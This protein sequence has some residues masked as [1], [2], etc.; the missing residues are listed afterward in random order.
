MIILKKELETYFDRLWP[1]TRSI[2]GNGLRKSFKILQEI[3]PLEL[4]EVATGKRVFDWEIPEEWNIRDA[5][6]ET[7][8]G[9]KIAQLADHNLHVVNYSEP[10]DKRI[11]FSELKAH[12]H[13]LPEQPNAIPYLTSYY[14]KTWGF[15]LTHN[16][17]KTLPEK[18]EYRVFIDSSLKPGS[19]TYGQCLLPGK[20]KKEVLFSSY[21]CHPSMANNELSG[22]LALAFLYKQ[23]AAIPE[24][25]Y[26]YRFVLAPETIGVIAFL[27]RF[28][29]QLQENITAGYVLTCCGDPGSFTYKRSKQYEDLCNR[30]AEHVLRYRYPE[31]SVIDFAVGGSDERQYCS[32][33]FNFPVGSLMRTP[34]QR[35]PEYHTSL[36]NKSFLSFEA[37]EETVQAYAQIVQVLEMNGPWKC[38]VPYCEPQLGKRGLYPSSISPDAQREH[39]HDLLHFI[40][41]ADGEH[42]L[43]SVADKRN[44]SALEFEQHL[45][46]CRDKGLI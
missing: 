2:T 15:C 6:I 23:L 4:T 19:L 7:P 16:E 42:D 35:Y 8:D 39:L 26:S 9:R 17:F 13:T 40:S 44:K 27:D 31:H 45:D 14:K 22:P 36:D 18:G 5:Y 11:S 12:L 20:S 29:S 3:I 30:A 33:G 34:Y 28:G 1:I 38:T 32:P 37:L 41:Y 25:E 10:V 24:R 21:L 43:I 46:A